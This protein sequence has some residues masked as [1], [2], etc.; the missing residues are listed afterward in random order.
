PYESIGIECAAGLAT[1]VN[2]HFVQL[3]PPDNPQDEER[4]SLLEIIRAY[5]LSL[6]NRRGELAAIQAAHAQYY[7]RFILDMGQRYSSPQQA[8]A[9]TACDRAYDNILAAMRWARERGRFTVLAELTGPLWWY[10]E[11]RR[12]LTEGREWIEGTLALYR[13]GQDVRAD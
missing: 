13:E 12:S 11:K 2:A 6:L 4:Y 9:L 5:G 7:Q 10:W 1:L 3:I 8:D